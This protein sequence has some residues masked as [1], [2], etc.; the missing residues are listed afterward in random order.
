MIVLPW[1]RFPLQWEQ[2]RRNSFRILKTIVSKQSFATK[3]RQWQKTF[4]RSLFSH[5]V[6]SCFFFHL[7]NP[8]LRSK[9]R[10]STDRAHR[11]DLFAFGFGICRLER[12]F[13]VFNVSKSKKNA[14][15]QFF[16]QSLVFPSF[17]FDL[18]TNQ[19]LF[20][21]FFHASI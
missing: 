18:L 19:L 20:L 14:S 9:F 5:V 16:F 7:L 6:L 10:E 13:F 12:G 2:Y 15:A 1:H 4:S 21:L 17:S 3:Q 11:V 8:F